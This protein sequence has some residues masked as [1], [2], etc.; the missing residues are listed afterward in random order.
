MIRAVWTLAFLLSLPDPRIRSTQAELTGALEAGARM[1][2]TL[3]ELVARIEA[4]DVVVYLVWNRSM[5][6]GVAARVS[7]MAAAGGRRYVRVAIDPV[8]GGCPLIGLLGHELQHVV[9]IAEEPSIVDE[10]SLAAFYRRIGFATGA[11]NQ[12]RF[13]S[14]AAIDVGRQVM[15]ETQAQGF[16]STA[17]DMHGEPQRMRRGSASTSATAFGA[18][19]SAK[20]AK[21]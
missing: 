16:G 20:G 9:E 8:H 10:R 19:G 3:Q 6:T 2:P 5:E 15:R 4:S 21:R 11:W 17:L 13:D 18:F 12:E 1:S 7:F 14:Q